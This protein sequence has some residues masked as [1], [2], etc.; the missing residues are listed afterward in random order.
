VD[1]IRSDVTEE[2]QLAETGLSSL[3]LPGVLFYPACCAL[4]VMQDAIRP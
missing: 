1:Q 4:A 2:Y 3:R